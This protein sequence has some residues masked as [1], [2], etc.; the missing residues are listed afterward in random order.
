MT[1][2]DKSRSKI[3]K[4]P[5]SQ[6]LI[7]QQSGKKVDG[8]GGDDSF[9]VLDTDRYGLDQIGSNKKVKKTDISTMV[10]IK[11][12]LRNRNRSHDPRLMKSYNQ[13]LK[14]Q[15]KSVEKIRTNTKIKEMINR[16]N[17]RYRQ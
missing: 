5:R 12:K 7:P 6:S 1:V 8:V 14:I 4:S 3:I 11:A 16:E 13:H 15:K 17:F 9:E 10:K 2:D